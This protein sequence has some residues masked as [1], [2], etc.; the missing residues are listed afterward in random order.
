MRARAELRTRY[1][2]I[3][4][5]ALIV[6]VIGGVVIA[7]AAGARRT[8][9]A[10]PR[11]LRAEKA[12]DVVVDVTGRDPAAVDRVLN[13]VAS[14]PQILDSGRITLAQG[15][16]LIPGRRKPGNVFPIVSLDG[17][18][19]FSINRPKILRGRMLDPRSTD[20][21]VPSSAVASDLGLNVGETVRMQYGGLFVYA[22]P[23]PGSKRPAP[24]P[25]HVVGIGAV[26]NM[27]QPLAGGYLPGVIVSPGFARAHPAFITP[28][29]TAAAI[30]F[31]HGQADRVAF[32]TE[33][34]QIA[35]SLPPHTRI[36][37][38]FNQFTQTVGVQQTTRAQAIALDVLAALVALAGL[39]IFGQA[40]AR[41]TFLESIEYPT[42]RSLGVSPQQLVA[43]GMIRAGLIGVVGAIVASVVGFLLSPL[44]PTGVA[45]I[46]E[47]H[48]GFSFD[49]VIVGLGALAI[50]LLVTLLGAIPVWRGATAKWTALGTAVVRRS[51]NRSLIA[52]AL[53]SFPPS[54]RA[55]VRMAMEPGAGRTAVPVRTATFGAA[56]SLVA[57]A[58]ALA[59]G[60][61]LDRLVTTPSLS[62]WNWDTIMFPSTNNHGT[63]VAEDKRLVAIIDKSPQVAEYSLGTIIGGRVGSVSG[64]LIV[65]MDPKRGSI[66]PSL[67]EGR[68]PV[69]PDEIALG[70]ETMR[71]AGA[72][73]GSTV[74]V[75]SD[76]G[77]FRMRVVGRIAVPP[78]FFAFIRPGQGAAVSTQAAQNISPSQGYPGG[79][80]ARF[81]PGVDQQSLVARLEN[82]IGG[83]IFVLPHTQSGQLNTLNQVGQTPVI[84]AGILA[85]MAAATLA[86]TLITSIR[87]RRL[88]IAILKTL[89]FVR[90]QV[91]ATVA[92]QATTL[93]AMALVIGVPVGVIAGRWGWNVFADHLGVVP[94][95]VIPAVM[96]FLAVPA[97]ILV[98]NLLAVVPGRIASR[99]RPGPV[100]RT[101]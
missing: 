23:P 78:L 95:A 66:T 69:G 17:R 50:L 7:A 19:G 41:Q 54:G 28:H 3:L 42:L 1:A 59:F 93:G 29:D 25:L 49:G 77:D 99:L 15:S 6:G 36:Q 35:H 44:T 91:S 79:I 72:S 74:P 4:S 89:G 38:P 94:D 76:G 32:R 56:I 37:I 62:G 83:G 101:E 21:I 10:Y 51:R 85:L 96:T 87:R 5:L 88:D 47:P 71:D 20:E 45:R 8:E 82:Q 12:M 27:F 34:S 61:S 52:R 26:P 97:T 84:L 22:Q 11:F 33:I 63:G 73:I 67:I 43:V 46:A 80:F 90:R 48:P 14:L 16:L 60:A 86:H 92:W 65:A 39:A 57:L 18:F 13:R 53:R 55:G 70:T 81:A 68:L 31:R 24:V 2:A 98:A 40:L 75:H 100:L 9:T 30:R 58:A 64:L